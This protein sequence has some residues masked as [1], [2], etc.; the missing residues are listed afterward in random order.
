MTTKL[1]TAGL[2][3][4][5]VLLAALTLYAAS[6]VAQ[7]LDEASRADGYNIYVTRTEA[8]R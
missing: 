4:L 2:A 7:R 3:F 5:W 8:P 1:K 6:L